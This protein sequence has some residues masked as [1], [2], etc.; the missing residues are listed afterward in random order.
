MLELAKE[1]GWEPE[2]TELWADDGEEIYFVKKLEW[3]DEGAYTDYNGQRM[4][5]RDMEKMIIALKRADPLE[6][7]DLLLDELIEFHKSMQD[8]IYCIY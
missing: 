6:L 2:G 8:S 4:S 7:A 3:G 5:Y 1:N